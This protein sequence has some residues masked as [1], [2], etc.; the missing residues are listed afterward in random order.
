MRDLRD[1]QNAA[2]WRPLD[3]VISLL[4]QKGSSSGNREA[5]TQS[6]LRI[7]CPSKYPKV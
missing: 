6:K 7:I 3:I 4:P 1:K 2:G 5:Y